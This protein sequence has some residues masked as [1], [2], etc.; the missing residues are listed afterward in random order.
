MEIIAEH[1][2]EKKTQKNGRVIKSYRFFVNSFAP[3][4]DA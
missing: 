4:L 1:L 2:W 3:T